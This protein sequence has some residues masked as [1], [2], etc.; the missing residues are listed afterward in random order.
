M[1]GC[2]IGQRTSTYTSVAD[3]S[4]LWI[5]KI[6]TTVLVTV[7]IALCS[8]SGL[9]PRLKNASFDTS[10]RRGLSNGNV[11]TKKRSEASTL[12]PQAKWPFSKL[13]RKSHQRL[14]TINQQAWR[15]QNSVWQPNHEHGVMS[16]TYELGNEITW[17]NL[18]AAKI[19]YKICPTPEQADILWA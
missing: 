2:C 6:N 5:S 4:S 10:R 19:L 9:R 15:M 3:V 13:I 8:C 18:T 1:T 11:R 12:S 17:C 14:V 7:Y 16:V